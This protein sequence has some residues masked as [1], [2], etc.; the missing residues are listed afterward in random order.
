MK[1]TIKLC[2]LVMLLGSCKKDGEEGG[3]HN[4]HYPSS[5]NG[6]IYYDWATEGILQVQLPLGD[7]GSFIPDKTKLNSFDVSR[8]GRY[9]LTSYRASSVGNNNV[10]FTLSNL[11]E[12]GI[13]HEFIYNAPGGS[14]YSKG[15]LSPDNS[16]IMVQSNDEEDGVTILKV[17]GEFVTR[18]TDVGGE[19]F[20]IRDM[21]M[22]MP[23]NEILLTH[24][25]N[26]IRL[27]PPYTTG[28]L[29]KRMEYED[30]GDLAV[31]HQGSQ[32]ALR[33]D[34][35]IYTMNIDG[36][37][38][39]QVTTSNFKEAVPVFSPNGKWLLVGADY[40]QTG[41]FGYV[42]DLKVIPTDGKLYN[43]GPI[44]SNSPE[45]VPVILKG[46]DRIE[47]AGG[48]VLWK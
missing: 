48:A 17:S 37:D 15:L 30:W 18:L 7:G 6:T 13:V 21:Q 32:M 11:K 47:I 9:R 2:I 39:K 24:G 1:I 8:D 41:P 26:I 12:G 29:V 20:G 27:A 35:H 44:E 22:W 25:K 33:I 5:L 28:K 16:L 36:S 31:N 3:A 19:P 34:R 43:V 40:R 4:T 42:W 14:S 45:V 46:K 38:K 23:N 10:Q